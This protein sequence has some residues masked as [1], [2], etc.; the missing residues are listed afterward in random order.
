[1]SPT[2]LGLED[3]GDEDGDGFKRVLHPLPASLSEAG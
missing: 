2:S 1:M 3:I